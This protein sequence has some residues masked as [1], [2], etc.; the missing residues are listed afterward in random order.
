MIII[1][2]AD[3]TPQPWRNGRGTTRELWAEPAGADVQ[4]RLSLADLTED[5]PFSRFDGVERV[6]TPVDGGGFE[7]TVDGRP[8]PADRHRPIR[9]PG[10]AA[11]TVR[12][13]AEPAR[14]LNLM[15]ARGHCGG[16]V[17]VRR[18]DGDI[19]WRG[20]VRSLFLVEGRL[21]IGEAELPRLGVVVATDAA[22]TGVAEDAL[23][24]EV[25]IFCDAPRGA[26]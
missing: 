17:H 15:T 22:L 12:G 20:G 9:F 3:T 26:A 21:T 8:H 6:F 7:L 10:E 11:V 19:T 4:W 13:L 14:A 5:G 16:T 2:S 25:R 23:I 1:D 24:A 18:Y